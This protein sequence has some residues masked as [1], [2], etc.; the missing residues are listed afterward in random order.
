MVLRRLEIAK[1]NDTPLVLL[2]SG[3]IKLHGRSMPENVL[4]FFEPITD[5]MKRYTEN[6]AAFT[7]I[8]LYL[9]YA[10][11]CSIKIITDLLRM[12]DSKYRQ[13]FDMKIAWTYEQNDE[14]AKETGLELESMLK[15]PFDH[16]EIETETKSK[17]RILVKN[18]LTGKTGEISQMYWETIKGNGHDKDFEILDS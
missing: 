10:N 5:W 9:T 18:L 17:K 12:L 3:H 7:N 6:P 8:D 13:G 14:S 2:E 11:S 1:S 16:I 15:I 4:I